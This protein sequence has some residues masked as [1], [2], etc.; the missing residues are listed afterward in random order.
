MQGDPIGSVIL[1]SKEPTISM[2]E[3]ELKL[4]ETAAGFLSKQMEN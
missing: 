2:G 3:L 1:I 4:T